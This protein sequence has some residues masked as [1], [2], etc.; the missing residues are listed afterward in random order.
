[1]PLFAQR[2]PR[3]TARSS[4]R[5][6]IDGLEPRRHFYAVA[7]S[8]DA[9]KVHQTIDSLG[10]ASISWLHQPEQEAASFYDGLVNDLGASGV[11]GAL[12]PNFELANDNADPNVFDWSKF[13]SAQLAH[14]L[15][16]DQRMKE[17]GTKSFFLSV[18]TPPY[19][20]KTNRSTNGGGS[21][22]ADMRAEFAEYLAAVVI[23]SKRDFGIDLTGIS[24]QNE[25]F[26]PEPYESTLYDAAQLRETVVAVQAKFAREGLPTK[27]IVNED[28]I[29]DMNRWKWFNQAILDDDEIDRSRLIVASHY[30]DPNQMTQQRDQLAGTGIPLW[31]TEVSGK[32]GDWTGGVR[33][34]RDVSDSFTRADASAFYYWTYND[35]SSAAPID[36]TPS[37][38]ANGVPNGKYNALKHFYK[39][40]R[41]GMKRLDTS[42]DEASGTRVS[43]FQDPVTHATTIVVL[44]S[45]G[46]SNTVTL[47]LKGLGAGTPLFKGFRSSETETW[48]SMG[49]VDA[50]GTS[51]QLVVP[52]LGMITLYNGPE[53]APVTGNGSPPLPIYSNVDAVSASPLRRAAMQGDL[54]EVNRLIST[55]ANVNTVDPVSGWTALHAA[56][57]GVFPSCLDIVNALLNAGA[58]PNAKDVDGFT[59]LHAAVMNTFS[60]YNTSNS[61]KPGIVS[62]L[63]AKGATVDARD[64]AGRTPLIW[65]GLA[66]ASTTYDGY[67]AGVATTLLSSGADRTLRD[68]AGRTAYDYAIQ[69]Y[70]APV[71]AV[72]TGT[73]TDTRGP[74]LR[75]GQ[76]V[77][78][79]N[80]VSLV[81]P[82][83]VTASLDASDV[84]VTNRGT[85]ATSSIGSL[86]ELFSSG[87]TIARA[88][89]TSRLPDGHYRLSIAAGA[90]TDPNGLPSAAMA[91]DFDVMLGDLDGDNHVNF[92]DLVVLAQ[93]YNQSGRT[94][95]QGDVNDDGKVDFSDLV[96]IAQHYNTTLP[97]LAQ[98]VTATLVQRAPATK[99]RAATAV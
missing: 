28:V 11:R 93:N 62:A 90:V 91:V 12:M 61:A 52:K 47:S 7:G 76:Y 46:V 71:A 85:G 78:D 41:P 25:P 86:S 5:L 32:S 68:N 2:P 75:F 98:L 27:I 97:P 38:M 8:I 20:M 81:I 55:G 45:G 82:E 80:Y 37:L 84:T 56:A 79:K 88:K 1:M 63:I 36:Q 4:S 73:N 67:N 16:F 49:N 92:T 66:P 77:R 69:E 13:D 24:I 17:R 64:N 44:N 53:I 65:S 3:R 29:G 74:S 30:S 87:L 96:V 39:Y 42:V 89:F 26:F 57:A 43:A 6:M 95:S 31:F 60:A 51:L 70:K 34:A 35:P 22:R 10:A 59:P 15:Q 33:S 14:V 40:V 54:A 19:W 9:T 48:V 58:N 94:L 18:W 21:L 50:S 83:N 23:A 99:K 72:L